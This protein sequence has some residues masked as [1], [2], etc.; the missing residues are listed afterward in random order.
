VVLPIIGTNVNITKRFK[1]NINTGGAW[2]IKES[3]LNYTIM[4][5]T[6]MLL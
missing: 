6:R 4:F 3:A 1:L 5:G 2:A